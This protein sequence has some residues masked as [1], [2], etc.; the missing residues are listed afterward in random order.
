MFNNKN[1]RVTG[2]PNNMVLSVSIG[3]ALGVVFAIVVGTE[4]NSSILPIGIGA[5]LA[6]GAAVG[7]MLSRRSQGD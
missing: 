1:K 5:G 6:I 4:E 7:A 2:K 3:L